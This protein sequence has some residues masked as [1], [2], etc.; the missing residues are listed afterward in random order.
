MFRSR[1]RIVQRRAEIVLAVWV[2]GLLPVIGSGRALAGEPVP[3][4]GPGKSS[5]SIDRIPAYHYRKIRY[6]SPGN[7]AA[8]FRDYD[9]PPRIVGIEEGWAVR[10]VGRRVEVRQEGKLVSLMVET[11]RWR[12]RWD[13]TRNV[14]IAYPSRLNEQGPKE[15]SSIRER[16]GVKRW[17]E[18][19]RA[20]YVSEKD[21]LSGEEV[22]KITFTYLADPERDDRWPIHGW[23][24]GYER[25]LQ[26][27]DVV[28]RT[29]TYWFDLKTQ[30]LVRRQCGCKPPKYYDW[31]DYPAPESIPRDLFRFEVPRDATLEINDPALG[32]QVVSEVEAGPDLRD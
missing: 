28:F 23:K 2:V 22:E 3:S 24:P 11:P 9:G 20:T 10:G 15:V 6:E 12:F 25:L 4:Q 30:L 21:R 19:A 7:P 29:R 8:D 5:S 32:R 14:V 27:P 31:V 18:R 1:A 16:K 26:S 17:S 13:V